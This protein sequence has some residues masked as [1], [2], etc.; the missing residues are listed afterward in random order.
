MLWA[1]FLPC[2]CY[3]SVGRHGG[4]QILNLGKGCNSVGVILHE[5][6]HSLGFWHEQSRSDRDKFVRIL[7]ENVF[8]GM[9]HELQRERV[10]CN[11][12]FNRILA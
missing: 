10:E 8:L 2:R 1:F 5:L 4:P 11:G 3:G 12:S 7:L 6:L 9:I